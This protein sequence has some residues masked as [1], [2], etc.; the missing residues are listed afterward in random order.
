MTKLRVALVSL[1]LMALGACTTVRN[2]EAAN[3]VHALL[4]SIRDNDQVAFDRHVDRPA[5][6]AELQTKVVAKA[7]SRDKTGLAAFFAPAL[8]D[9]AGDALLQPYVFRLVAEHYGYRADMAIPGPLAIASVLKPLPDGRVCAT[10]KKAGP[11]ELTFAKIDGSWRLIG[12]EGD[13]SLLK[14][15]P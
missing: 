8:A 7:V 15:R 4:L 1:A 3:D 14:I 13:A 9:I 5:L 11:C 12:F 2:L 10:R 6:K